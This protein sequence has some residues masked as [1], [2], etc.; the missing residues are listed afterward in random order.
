MKRTNATGSTVNNLFTNGNPSLSIPA[1]VVDDSWLNSL[2]EEA[3]N[4]IEAAGLTLDQTGVDD[5]QLLQAVNLLIASGGQTQLSFTVA[6][7]IGSPTNITGLLF[8]ANVTKAAIVE[9]AISR[10]TDT[11]SSEVFEVGQ[12][13]FIYDDVGLAWRSASGGSSFDDSAVI[14]SI[15]SGGQV[16]YTSSNISGANYVGTMKAL[17]RKIKV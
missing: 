14:F 4:V 6:N 13:R 7:N 3:A 17:I 8:D 12:Q 9:Y 1:T 2:Q 11:A 15:T 10:K 5:T 16:R